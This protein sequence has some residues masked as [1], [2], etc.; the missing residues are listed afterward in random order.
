LIPIDRESN[1]GE[2]F[3][4]FAARVARN[5]AELHQRGHDR[6]TSI[7]R[8][9][10]KP[11]RKTKQRHKEQQKRSLHENEPSSFCVGGVPTPPAITAPTGAIKRMCN[12]REVRAPVKGL[13]CNLRLYIQLIGNKQFARSSEP[14]VVTSCE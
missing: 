11:R 1:S 12:L 4:W 10:R 13:V 8:L 14:T 3:E 5:P 6:P 7:G 2:T 9:L